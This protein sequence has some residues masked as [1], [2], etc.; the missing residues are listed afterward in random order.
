MEG[1][2]KEDLDIKKINEA[3]EFLNQ[4]AKEKLAEVQEMVSDKYADLKSALGGAAENLH[5]RMRETFDQDREKVKDF[6]SKVDDGVHRN[7]WP[8]IGGAAIGFL[9]LG[10][11]LGRSRK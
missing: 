1:T 11:S 7:P 3:L 4:A 8:Y 10:F 6:A 5:E 9:I 2:M